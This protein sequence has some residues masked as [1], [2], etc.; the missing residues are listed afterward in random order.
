MLATSPK[1]VPPV[2]PDSPLYACYAICHGRIEYNK[3]LCEF[4][5]EGNEQEVKDFWY[6]FGETIGG[7]GDTFMETAKTDPDGI[8]SKY[9]G[10]E[11]ILKLLPKPGTEFD[12][13][14]LI[15]PYIEC[16]VTAEVLHTLEQDSANTI[17]Q[18]HRKKVKRI[19]NGK[20]LLAPFK[21]IVEESEYFAEMADILKSY[22]LQHSDVFPWLL[23]G[24]KINIASAKQC[25]TQELSETCYHVHFN[26]HA[27]VQAVENNI[28]PIIDIKTRYED[29]VKDQ[30]YPQSILYLLQS[31]FLIKNNHHSFTRGLP[32]VDYLNNIIK[33]YK[34]LLT[35]EAS[36]VAFK[37]QAYRYAELAA[38]MEQLKLNSP[39][40]AQPESQT[41]PSAPITEITPPP[42][43]E[44]TPA[45]TPLPELIEDIP[46]ILPPPPIVQFSQPEVV[47]SQPTLLSQL[48]KKT[49]QTLEILFSSNIHK[50]L[51]YQELAD[52]INALGGKIIN[53]KGSKRRIEVQN[54]FC[55]TLAPLN[56]VENVH[57]PHG[58]HKM[59]D[60]LPKGIA[61]HFRRVLELANLKPET[62]LQ[63]IDDAA[64]PPVAPTHK[65]A[66]RAKRK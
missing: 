2:T 50:K 18:E 21:E 11:D 46:P 3:A 59:N 29:T 23:R 55:D 58:K 51:C 43:V 12:I 35:L 16:A 62:I 20:T 66:A 24:L 47:S 45:T 65:S 27:L 22:L 44:D 53:L 61:M 7:I 13:N 57:E 28:K 54:R 26:A 49:K 42:V 33:L 41:I 6:S 52:L 10:Y 34:Q 30:N 19:R 9:Q 1:M 5:I 64:R 39:P 25:I 8:K 60:P 14:S 40:V 15:M 37:I 38:K 17:L 31:F 32:T 56:C 48:N 4:L 36:A 63:S